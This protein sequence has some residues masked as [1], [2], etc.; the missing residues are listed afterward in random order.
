MPA[1]IGILPDLSKATPCPAKPETGI[2]LNWERI[3]EE[4]PT[5]RNLALSQMTWILW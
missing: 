1:R 5:T 2:D 4:L 3:L